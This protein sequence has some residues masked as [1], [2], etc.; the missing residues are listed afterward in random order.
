[1]ERSRILDFART[2]PG[3][4]H[5]DAGQFVDF[6]EREVRRHAEAEAWLHAKRVIERHIAEFEQ[7]S[8]M[9]ASEAFV[10]R[11]VC[12]ELARE[13]RHVEPRIDAGSEDRLAGPGVL[14][15]IEPEAQLLVRGFV[16]DVAQE[17]ERRTWREVVRYAGG[18]GRS[19]VRDHVLSTDLT[20]DMERHYA[21]TAAKVL[22][23]LAAEC[24]ERARRAGVAER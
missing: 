13:L 4:I 20:W 8:G 19:L 24:E 1:M 22:R 9:P 12:H 6:T 15:E 18:R 2:H 23:I 14:N 3:A 16:H 5:G 11:E 17:A 7:D 21:V 10:A